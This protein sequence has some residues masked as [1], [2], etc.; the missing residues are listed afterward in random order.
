MSR[1]GHLTARL[2][3]L[4]WG[5]LVALAL[6]TPSRADEPRVISLF[7]GQNLGGWKST[8]FG[9]EGEVEV[10]DE[11]IVVHQGSPLSGIHWTEE[12]PQGDFELSFEAKR[13]QGIDFFCGVT[14]PVGEDHC[15]FIV[16]GWAGAVVG[17]SSI[18]GKDASRNDT[19]KYMKFDNDRWYAMRVRVEGRRIRCWIDDEMVVDQDTTGKKLTLRSEVLLSRPLGLATF[20][21]KAAYRNLQWR[22]LAAE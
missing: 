2:H 6:G 4:A 21:T 11:T 22:T 19:T 15:S 13:L 9:G 3:G 12:L 20:E 1:S 8:N 10:V 5:L 7:D 17:L 14:F 16:G 18:D